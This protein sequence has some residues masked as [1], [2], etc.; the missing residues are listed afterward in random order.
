MEP[1]REHSRTRRSGPGGARPAARRP[2]GAGRAGAR[3]R[4]GRGLRG[5]FRPR[6]RPR[7]RVGGPPPSGLAEKHAVWRA[8]HDA[9]GLPDSTADDVNLTDGQARV[10]VRADEREEAWAPRFVA[11]E[12]AATAQ[13][14]ER[15]RVDAQCGVHVPPSPVARPRPPDSGRT[16]SRPKPKPRTWRSELPRRV[17]LSVVRRR[18][19]ARRRSPARAPFRRRRRRSDRRG[20]GRRAWRRTAPVPAGRAARARRWRR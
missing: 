20:P 12:L 2:A 3:R 15:A 4:V 16:P 11:D 5:A 10:R 7:R 17:V 13:A 1:T 8:A 18:G 19:T 14:A 6:R 9:L